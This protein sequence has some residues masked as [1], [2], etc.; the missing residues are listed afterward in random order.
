MKNCASLFWSIRRDNRKEQ[1][2]CEV[3]KVVCDSVLALGFGE[4]DMLRTMA[5]QIDSCTL[6]LPLI[7]NTKAI[8]CREELVCFCKEPPKETKP[9]QTKE[10]TWRSQRTSLKNGK[11]HSASVV[12]LL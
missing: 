3:V 7:T 6:S 5:P 10:E 9:R 1:C 4:S 12:D 2:K 11:P 8:G